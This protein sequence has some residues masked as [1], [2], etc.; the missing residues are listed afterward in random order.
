LEVAYIR[1]MKKLLLFALALSSGLTNWSQCE[2][3]RYRDLIFAETDQIQDIEYGSNMAHDGVATTLLLDVFTPANDTEVNRPLVILAHG[4]FFISGSKEGLDVAPA[5]ND[6]AKM[7]YVTASINYRLGFPSTL[8]LAGPM[9]EAV[10]R[11]VQD[12]KAAVRFFRKSVAED[13]NPYGI[14]PN[15]IYVGGFSAG[16]FIALHYAYLQDDEIPSNVNQNANGLAGGVEGESGHAG[17]STQINAIINIAGAIGDTL[18]IEAGDVPALLAHGSSDTV[19]PFDSDMLTIQG[20]LEV[21]QVDGS[22]SVDQ[23]LTQL[24]IEHCFEI[25]ELQGHVPS[26]TNPAY[27]DTTL[28]KMANF[29]SHFV[30]PNTP[31]D[32]DYRELIV[33]TD[34]IEM[35]ATDVYPIPADQYIE[36]RASSN[37]DRVELYNAMGQLV[38]STN[39]ND[40]Q[41]GT[42]DLPNGIYV[43]RL[44]RDNF[45]E[46]H[47]ILINH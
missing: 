38:I 2:D 19:V 37:L 21:A 42:A 43:L 18:W 32:C 31:L 6:L 12:M 15:Q 26:A 34:E 8:N 17:Y 45:F 22:N 3:G 14:D 13:G 25:Y 9:T 4:G 40:Q 27:Y 5:C 46:D 16:G 35:I 7:G 28:S 23:K 10:M 33:G 36:W 39:Q 41:I 20:F 29:L 47:K 24:D 30:C 11:G 1:N 44:N